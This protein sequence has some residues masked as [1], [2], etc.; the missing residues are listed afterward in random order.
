MPR[1]L[2][3]S[4]RRE[5]RRKLYLRNRRASAFFYFLDKEW[6]RDERRSK[7]GPRGTSVDVKRS[8]ERRQQRSFSPL[9]HGRVCAHT[10]ASRRTWFLR[11]VT[12]RNKRAP[13][14]CATKRANKK[15]VTSERIRR[16][17][18]RRERMISPA[19]SSH[20]LKFNSD[21]CN[22]VGERR[23]IP[24]DEQQQLSSTFPSD[25]L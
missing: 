13:L 5:K 14:T 7:D 17:I 10:S 8:A 12:R 19:S 20:F 2:R 11:P 21:T 1:L 23:L 25:V 16:T 18:A 22:A 9:W 6:G 3:L 24:R 4:A 15:D